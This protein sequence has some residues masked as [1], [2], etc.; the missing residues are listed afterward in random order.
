MIRNSQVEK[1]FCEICATSEVLLHQSETKK[2][3]SSP[4]LP[5][6]VD[7]NRINYYM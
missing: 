4:P 7:S 2:I 3:Y 1:R 6:F 5:S